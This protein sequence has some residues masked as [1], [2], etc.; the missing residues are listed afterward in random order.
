MPKA[1]SKSKAQST[2]SN[3]AVIYLRVSTEEQATMGVSLEA[4]LERAKSYCQT[5]NLNVVEVISDEGVSGFTPL[6][7]RQG[8]KRLL[9]LV[10]AGIAKHVVVLKLDRLFRNASNAHEVIT[11][12]DK[13]GVTL[14]LIDMGGQSLN[15]KT[16]IGKMF[17]TI[18]SGFAEFERNLIAERTKLALEHKKSR[19]EIY[20]PVPF[21]FQR[22]DGRLIPDETEMNA[23]RLMFALRESGK[24]LRAIISELERIGV[25][26][27]KSTRWHPRVVAYILK[28]HSLY[29]PYL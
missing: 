23:V 9:K 29:E 17:F 7:E 18:L 24:S 1:I 3:N 12:W 2:D 28:N 10:E 4:Q 13:L 26:P 6:N 14:H 20:S 15:T 16:A 22:V 25:K 8:G 11:D 19:R 21:G 27:K 5:H